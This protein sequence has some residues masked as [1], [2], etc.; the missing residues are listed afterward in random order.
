VLLLKLLCVTAAVFGYYYFYLH[1]LLRLAHAI[2]KRLVARTHRTFSEIAGI[3]ELSLFATSHVLFCIALLLSMG[4]TPRALVLR[5]VGPATVL[6]GIVLG[7]AEMGF[8]SFLCRLA[9]ETTKLA[10]PTKAPQDLTSW[11]TIAKGGWM[12]HHLRTVE[13][14]PWPLI[15]VLLVM[16]ISSEEIV[17]RGVVANV[18]SAAGTVAAVV[19]SALLFSIIQGFLMPS[20]QSAMFPIIGGVVMGVVHG[21]LYMAVPNVVPL[22]VAHLAFFAFAIK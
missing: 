3:V 22:V 15:A 5:A 13:V 17:F 11:L 10:L 6:F 7:I 20:W 21:M 18:A 12:R 19:L 16:Q 2:S 1:A 9:I 4:L 14:A 8:A